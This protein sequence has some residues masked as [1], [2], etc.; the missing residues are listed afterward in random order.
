MINNPTTLTANRLV[1]LSPPLTAPLKISGTPELSL[2]ASADQI[3]TNLGVLLVDYGT[4]TRVAWNQSGEGITTLPARP[5]ERGLLG[6]GRREPADRERVLPEDGE[7]DPDRDERADHEGHPRRGQPQ[8]VRHAG[9]PR[10]RPGVRL[11]FPLLPEDFV[12]PGR[13]PARRRGRGQLLGLLGLD[14]AERRR[15]APRHGRTSPCRGA[16]ARS[17]CRSSAARAPRSPRASEASDLDAEGPARAGP[18]RFSAARSGC[19][20]LN[21]GPLRPERSALPGCATPRARTG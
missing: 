6:R 4:A 21:W 10:P 8:L 5:G 13:A 2:R 16:S 12:D 20:D 1:Y 17:C 14:G 18:S 19:P 3:D 11:Q 15:T 7:A 9:E